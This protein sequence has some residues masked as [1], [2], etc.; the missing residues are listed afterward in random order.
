MSVQKSYTYHPHFYD[1]K[2]INVFNRESFLTTM[3]GWE[4]DFH[5]HFT[6]C[7]ANFLTGSFT[8]MK[9]LERSLALDSFQICG[10]QLVNG[11]I[12]L[13]V[14]LSIEKHSRYQTLYAIDSTLTNVNPDAP[15]FLILDHRL[16]SDMVILRYIEGGDKSQNALTFTCENMSYFS[17]RNQTNKTP[18]DG[19]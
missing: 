9:L 14:H 5:Q 11:F 2:A 7:F 15:L 19:N 1:R 6:Y 12:D 8:T 3:R 17:T 13:D 4:E 16:P 18:K 10:M